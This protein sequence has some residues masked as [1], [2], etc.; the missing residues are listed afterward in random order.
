[1]PVANGGT[2]ITSLGTGVATFLGTPSSANFYSALTSKTGSGG[3]VVFG[4]SPTIATPT[5]TGLSLSSGTPDIVAAT[6]KIVDA[7]SIGY[8]DTPTGTYT[9]FALAGLTS[10]K[11]SY[12]VIPIGTDGGTASTTLAPTNHPHTF[13]TS[14]NFLIQGNIVTS[15]DLGVPPFFMSS[16]WQGGA[17][18]ATTN[19]VEVRH[20]VG[21][22]PTNTAL[23][24]SGA[25][26]T[27]STG[28]TGTGYITYTTSASH[29]Y[30]VGQKITVIGFTSTAFNVSNAVIT[31]LPSA[32]PTTKFTITNTTSASGTASGTGSV[33]ASVLVT[34]K[35]TNDGSDWAGT[36]TANPI[37]SY[38]ITPGS[39]V[40]NSVGSWV[41]G[42]TI[43]AADSDEIA[44]NIVGISA[45][46]A[47]QNLS[48]TLVFEH[49]LNP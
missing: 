24:A 29:N 44:L 36:S 42:S 39:Y 16:G 49:K 37:N 5:I 41:P 40:Y 8:G 21:N 27:N 11:V 31:G 46:F 15:G 30:V 33:T 2:G 9:A 22:N 48:V 23:T 47:P 12:K 25:L 14:H 4:T 43:T 1:L 13:R 6:N 20:K 35:L 38:Y 19:L 18:S 34:F 28:G 7:K 3:S 32:S 26:V 45:G 17:S 10:G